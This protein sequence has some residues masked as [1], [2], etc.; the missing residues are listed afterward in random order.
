MACAHCERPLC[1]LCEAANQCAFCKAPVASVS[2]EV[3]PPDPERLE[4]CV[5]S[6]ESWSNE[7]VTH[8]R[9]KR[10]ISFR[11]NPGCWLLIWGWPLLMLILFT[12]GMLTEVAQGRASFGQAMG[13][14]VLVFLLLTV[15]LL[16]VRTGGKAFDQ[17]LAEA[18]AL[19]LT[20]SDSKAVC[21]EC[22]GAL[23]ER[24]MGLWNCQSC[25]TPHLLP[26]AFARAKPGDLINRLAQ[27]KQ[28]GHLAAIRATKAHELGTAVTAN[29]YKFFSRVLLVGT[30]VLALVLRG[31]GAVN[32]EGAIGISV[33]GVGILGG[34][35]WGMGRHKRDRSI[36]EATFSKATVAGLERLG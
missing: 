16:P 31:I 9:T 36:H 13:P 21:L 10:S 14:L 5:R 35:S 34:I 18:V 7:I 29:T 12:L 33:F 23:I 32:T 11:K 30:P 15:V 22:E 2:E 6:H 4:T 27:S 19:P 1:A 20:R 3:P 8:Q 17:F 26:I 24:S 28:L 25:K